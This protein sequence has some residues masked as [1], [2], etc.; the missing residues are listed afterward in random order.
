MNHFV[1]L[2]DCLWITEHLV[3]NLM[4]P[5]GFSVFQNSFSRESL[6]IAAFSTHLAFA[7][8]NCFVH[9]RAFGNKD[10]FLIKV[11]GAITTEN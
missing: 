7:S 8:M 5:L 9:F 3:G 2:F 1:G 10:L 6:K 4:G 11:Y